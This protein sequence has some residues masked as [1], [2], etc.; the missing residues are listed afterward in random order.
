MNREQIIAEITALKNLLCQS[1]HIP[2]KL[3][4]G[5]VLAIDGATAINAVTRLLTA[6]ASALDEYRDVVRNRATWRTRINEL[7]AELEKFPKD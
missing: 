3:I 7:E 4:E 2:N 6:V 5:I 1:D